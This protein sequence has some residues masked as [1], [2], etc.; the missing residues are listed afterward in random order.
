MTEAKYF[1]ITNGNITFFCMYSNLPSFHL[2]KINFLILRNHVSLIGNRRLYNNLKEKYV[3]GKKKEF[4]DSVYTRILGTS[5]V[6]F[7]M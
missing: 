1:N 3:G 2:E 6:F 7:V 5:Q 4:F